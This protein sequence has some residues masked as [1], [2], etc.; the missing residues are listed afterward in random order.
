MKGNCLFSKVFFLFKDYFT[1]WT[2]ILKI[3]KW[4]KNWTKKNKGTPPWIPPQWGNKINNSPPVEGCRFRG[5]EGAFYQSSWALVLWGRE[6]LIW[7]HTR[8]PEASLFEAVRISSFHY[9]KKYEMRLPRRIR[10]SSQWRR[11]KIQV[12]LTP[13]SKRGNSFSLNPS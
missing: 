4:V 8:H 9:S 12:F 5:G 1:I 13:F 2:S 6:D 11:Y 10:R 7:H 3:K